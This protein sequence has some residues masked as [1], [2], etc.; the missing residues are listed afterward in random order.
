MQRTVKLHQQK[1]QHQLLQTKKLLQRLQQSKQETLC[2]YL[3]NTAPYSVRP[4]IG[5]RYT[6]SHCC[7]LLLHCSAASSAADAILP[8]GRI[9]PV[10]SLLEFYRLGCHITRGRH[11]TAACGRGR[12][13][14]QQHWAHC[15]TGPTRARYRQP[16]Q[17]KQCQQKLW[18]HQVLLQFRATP[19]AA[20]AAAAIG[21]GRSSIGVEKR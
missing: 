12:Q 7:M 13:Q 16:V 6:A 5:R 3:T 21:L 20:L 4:Y 17:P 14:K 19:A 9:L 18:S 15:C 10:G 11:I 8:T 2:R 1:S